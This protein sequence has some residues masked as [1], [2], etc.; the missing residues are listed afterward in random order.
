MVMPKPEP[1]NLPPLTEFI[2]ALRY[3]LGKDPLYSDAQSRRRD[4][5]RDAVG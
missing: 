2:D 5:E 3:W 4:N 1:A